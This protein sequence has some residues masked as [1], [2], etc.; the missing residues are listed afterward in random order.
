V[1]VATPDVV[2]VSVEDELVLVDEED[3]GEELLVPWDETLVED[4][5]VFDEAADDGEELVEVL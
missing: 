3:A 4:K 2:E 1:V 5:V